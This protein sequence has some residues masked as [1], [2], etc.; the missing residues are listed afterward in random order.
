MLPLGKMLDIEGELGILKR[1]GRPGSTPSL[2]NLSIFS[3]SCPIKPISMH[4]CVRNCIR[5]CGSRWWT[6]GKMARGV[7][8]LLRTLFYVKV[9]V[10][11]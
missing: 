1:R 3:R 10:D 2:L 9:P 5:L 8:S 6:Y 4:S 7:H 11:W